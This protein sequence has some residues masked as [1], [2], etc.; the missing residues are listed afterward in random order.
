M[1]LPRSFQV[2]LKTVLKIGSLSRHP[3]KQGQSGNRRGY[4]QDVPPYPFILMA[5]HQNHQ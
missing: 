4:H 2:V 1:R 5:S 3:V